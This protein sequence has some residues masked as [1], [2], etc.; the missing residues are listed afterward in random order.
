LGFSGASTD[1]NNSFIAIN[2]YMISKIACC[3]RGVLAEKVRTQ[4]K[5]ARGGAVWYYTTP[6]LI[7]KAEF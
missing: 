5:A 7:C 2:P 4:H 6:I 1:F 3:K